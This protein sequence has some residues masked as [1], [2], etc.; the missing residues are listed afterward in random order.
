M[1]DFHIFSMVV[2]VGIAGK[3]VMSWNSRSSQSRDYS[4]E[5]SCSL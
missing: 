2:L 5:D 4:Y 3:I 1:V